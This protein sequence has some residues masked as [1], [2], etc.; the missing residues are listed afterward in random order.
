MNLEAITMG[1]QFAPM[2]AGFLSRVSWK[3]TFWVSGM[4]SAVCFVPLFFLPE[5]YAPVILA[6]RAQKLRKETGD[7]SI[8]APIE[9][10]K[11]GWKQ[12]IMVFL[13]RPIRMMFTESLVTFTCVYLA[14]ETGIYCRSSQLVSFSCHRLLISHQTSFS[15]PIPSFSRPFTA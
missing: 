13:A 4:A 12:I 14:F 3:W 10:E 5:T 1:P 2:I 9:L 15:R 6:K 11:K 8:F 7:A